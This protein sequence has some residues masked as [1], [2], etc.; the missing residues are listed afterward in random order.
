MVP[1]VS[2]WTAYVS[3][4]QSTVIY[5]KSTVV[6]GSLLLVYSILGKY[7]CTEVYGES[8]VAFLRRQFM[9]V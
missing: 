3:V 2:I 7:K 5:R 4:G 9:S 6:D 1:K 8:T